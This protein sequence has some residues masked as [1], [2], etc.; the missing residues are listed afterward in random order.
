MRSWLMIMSAEE[1][2]GCCEVEQEQRCFAKPA[3]KEESQLREGCRHANC[4]AFNLVG[5][6]KKSL[7]LFLMVRQIW[8]PGGDVNVCKP[9]NV[10]SRL[11]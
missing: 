9:V 4:I 7:G 3:F 11:V 8:T 5:V 2:Q 6:L 10:S 1:L